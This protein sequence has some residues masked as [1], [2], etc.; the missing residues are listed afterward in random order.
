MRIAIFS[1][2]VIKH[3]FKNDDCLI[4]YVISNKVYVSVGTRENKTKLVAKHY[5]QFSVGIAISI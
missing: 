3:L 4:L 2:F 1:N 5:F